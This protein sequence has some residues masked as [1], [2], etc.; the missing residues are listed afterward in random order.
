[1]RFTLHSIRDRMDRAGVVLSGLC[2]LHCVASLVILSGLGIGG[3]FLLAPVIHEV[4][5]AL[6]C[7]IAGVAIGW[8]AIRHR[9]AAPFVVAMM[10]LTFMGGALASPHGAQEAVLTIIGVIMV[11]VGHVLNLRSAH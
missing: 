10:G 3:S 6:A 11:S 8:G 7:V 2:A 5:L 4:G 1:M 9:R